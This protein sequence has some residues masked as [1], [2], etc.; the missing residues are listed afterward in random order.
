MVWSLQQD[1]VWPWSTEEEEE[2]V[3]RDFHITFVKADWTTDRLLTG[4]YLE[5]GVS[6][7][8]RML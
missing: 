5:I 4:L 8:G 1:E 3:V 6:F 2:D 7:G